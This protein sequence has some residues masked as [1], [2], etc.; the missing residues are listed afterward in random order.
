M[1]VTILTY[2]THNK[3]SEYLSWVKTR[4]PGRYNLASSGMVRYSIR[5][6]AARVEDIEIRDAQA[7]QGE[8]SKDGPSVY[9]Y[10]FAELT[11]I[12]ASLY[13]ARAARPSALR[14]SSPPFQGGE[15]SV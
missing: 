10:T 6:L 7:R 11:T 8:A 9:G 5:E 12:N 13:R 15:C 3:A 2:M 4:Q 1:T 14:A